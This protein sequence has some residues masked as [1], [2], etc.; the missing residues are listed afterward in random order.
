MTSP[1]SMRSSIPCTFQTI[2]W[3]PNPPPRPCRPCCAF[4]RLPTDH[5]LPCLTRAL[6]TPRIVTE[7]KAHRQEVSH[8]KIKHDSG[9]AIM[10]DELHSLNQQT[11]KYKRERDTYKTMLEGAQRTIGDLK[12][13]SRAQDDGGDACDAADVSGLR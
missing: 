1:S 5:R 7:E 11:S 6:G 12:R 13:K 3:T 9:L 10:K 8:L 2:A 4:L